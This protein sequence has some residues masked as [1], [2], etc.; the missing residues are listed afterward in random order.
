MAKK[1]RSPTRAVKSAVAAGPLD[2]G[3]RY[4]SLPIVA[5]RIFGRAVDPNRVSLILKSARKW[6]NGTVLH[7]Y[8]FDQPT[9]GEQVVYQDGTTEFLPWTG[10]EKQKNVVRR[11]FEK[12]KELGIGLEF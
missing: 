4:C 2:S 12:W 7:Y 1:T 8:F 11:A 3:R 9:D 6:A 10:P 5:P